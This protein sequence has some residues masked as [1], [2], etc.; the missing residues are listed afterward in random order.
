M[1]LDVRCKF[2]M[3]IIISVIAFSEKDMIYGSMVFAVVCL[4]SFLL[5][6][7]KKA[8]R[9]IVI[10]MILI[11]FILLA[12]N[13]PVF[14]RSMLLMI[15]LCIRINMAETFSSMGVPVFATDIKGDLSGVSEPHVFYRNFFI[16]VGGVQRYLCRPD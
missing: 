12:N 16:D 4:L 2:L 10:Y 11:A 3:L 8:I 5:G 7:G 1:K 13:I 14:L 9:Y 15:V 6:Q